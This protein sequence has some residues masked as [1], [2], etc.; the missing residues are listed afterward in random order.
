MVDMKETKHETFR[1]DLASFESG[2]SGFM[3]ENREDNW[4]PTSCTFFQDS[5]KSKS[6]AYC[7]FEREF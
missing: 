7:S 3:I 6:W 1:S 2:F 5:D 4:K